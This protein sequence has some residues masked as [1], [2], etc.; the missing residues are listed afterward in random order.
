MGSISFVFSFLAEACASGWM[1]DSS[2]PFSLQSIEARTE[3]EDAGP[4]LRQ[5]LGGFAQEL[6]EGGLQVPGLG[7]QVRG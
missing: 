3:L 5:V 6:K 2:P 1:G 7:Y 4:F